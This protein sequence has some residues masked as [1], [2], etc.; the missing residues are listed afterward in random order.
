M[1]VWR[2]HSDLYSKETL[3]DC[4]VNDT[5]TTLIIIII[6]NGTWQIWIFGANADI[7]IRERE[8][9]PILIYNS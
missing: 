9:N 5:V 7:D 3:Y 4:I 6:H 2:K 1:K 8:K